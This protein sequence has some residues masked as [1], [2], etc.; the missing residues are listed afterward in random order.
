MTPED[1]EEIHSELLADWEM[2]TADPTAKITYHTIM[3]LAKK[4]KVVGGKW[5]CNFD[6]RDSV[7]DTWMYMA[8]AMAADANPIPCLA[9]KIAPLNDTSESS[10]GRTSH[11]CSVYTEDFTDMDNV[12]EVEK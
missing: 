10:F 3:Q 11:M 6:R 7:D 12:F 8:S 4:H 5:L 9:A 1:L 2:L